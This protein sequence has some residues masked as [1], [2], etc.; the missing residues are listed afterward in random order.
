MDAASVDSSP[1]TTDLPCAVCNY[2]LRELS[3]AGL[4]P[5]CGTPVARSF[6]AR[7]LRGLSPAWLRSVQWGITVAIFIDFAAIA[8]TSP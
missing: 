7:H 5:E 6:K 3:R 1:L 2:N 4:C 8:L